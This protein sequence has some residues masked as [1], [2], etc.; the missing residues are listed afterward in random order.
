MKFK[1]EDSIHLHAEVGTDETNVLPIGGTSAQVPTHKFARIVYGIVM[2]NTASSTNT[3]TIRI[4]ESD[5]STL[6]KALSFTLGAYDTIDIS[7]TPEAP[8]LKI[9]AGKIIKAVASAASVN[10][11]MNC[12]DI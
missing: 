10:L 5:G 8:I 12:Y 2:N 4:Y 3:L 6:F 1:P 11:L 9:P 7:R